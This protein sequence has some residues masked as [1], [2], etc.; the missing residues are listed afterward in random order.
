L[1]KGDKF[2][3]VNEE[4]EI[5]KH[6]IEIELIRFPDKFTIEYDVD[7][8]IANYETLKLILQPIVE[9]S[10]K[11]GISSL[12]RMGHILIKAYGDENSIIYEIIDDGI[13]F[14]PAEDIITKARNPD[15]KGGYGLKN[16]DERIKLE[17]GQE[18][19][20]SISSKVGGGTKVTIRIKKRLG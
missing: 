5:I 3:T 9:N 20:I 18:Y 14:N 6:F 10:I 8:D 17:Y 19:G 7:P 4:I 15:S 12:E 13:G 16:V 1:H 11:H 2:I